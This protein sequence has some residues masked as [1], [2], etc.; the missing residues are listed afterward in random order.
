MLEIYIFPRFR[1]TYHVEPVGTPRLVFFIFV[2]VHQSFATARVS[3]NGIN[4]QRSSLLDDPGVDKGA[5]QADESSRVAA[6]VGN[7]LGFT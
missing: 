4:S 2:N 5:G 1:H 3:T 6:R 7:S